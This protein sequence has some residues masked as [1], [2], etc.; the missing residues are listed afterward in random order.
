MRYF[1]LFLFSVIFCQSPWPHTN[2]HSVSHF[3]LHSKEQKC[4]S[5]FK[6]AKAP[7]RALRGVAI[8]YSMHNEGILYHHHHLLET[9]PSGDVA[10]METV[11]A[12]GRNHSTTMAISLSQVDSFLSHQC[13]YSSNPYLIKNYGSMLSEKHSRPRFYIS[14]RNLLKSFRH[15]SC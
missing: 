13:F 1:M 9:L 10:E 11:K 14:C 3:T 4:H 15:V 5:C 12:L 7:K 2:K 6:S 8:H